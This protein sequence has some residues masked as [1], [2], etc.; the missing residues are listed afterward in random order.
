MDDDDVLDDQ[1]A[2]FDDR[3][4]T[5]DDAYARTGVHDQ[6]PAANE[7]WWRELRALEAALARADLGGDVLE[8]GCGTGYWTE[9]LASR[10]RSVTALDGSEHMLREARRR[11]GDAPNVAFERVDL[12]RAWTPTRTFDAVAAFFFVEHV[13]DARLDALLANIAAVLPVGGR[14]FIADGLPHEP[15]TATEHHHAHEREYRM[16]E[17][18]RTEAELVAALE[19]HGFDVDVRGTEHLF[20]YLDGTR[21]R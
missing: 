17:R 14:L 8:L 21:R 3:A 16:V 2:Y 11:M 12:L 9:Q 13:P 15:S 5:Y 10:A 19:D 18:R 4:P 7:R 1:L 20:R 6:G